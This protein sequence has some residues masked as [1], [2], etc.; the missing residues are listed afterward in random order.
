M[1]NAGAITFM[2]QLLIARPEDE[3]AYFLRR[4][5]RIAAHELAHQWFGDLVTTA[6]WDDIWL[7]EA[8]ATWMTGKVLAALV[9]EWR[10]GDDEAGTTDGAMDED[11]L[12]S[13]RRIRQ[14]IA[15]KDDIFNA[16][17]K[18]TYDKGAAVIGMFERWVGPDR[19]RDGIRRYLA[20]FAFGTATADQFL[21][22]V[23]EAAEATRPLL[24]P[25]HSFLDQPGVPVVAVA[26]QCGDGKGA[27][28]Q[29]GQSR[30]AP[31]GAAAMT[32][33]TWQIPVCARWGDAG[34]E[35]G[36]ACTLLSSATASLSLGDGARCPTWVDA[37]PARG[38][39]R[40][41]YDAR[42]RTRLAA[43]R[44]RAFAPAAR[45]GLLDDAVALAHAG[46]LPFA[47]MLRLAAA[48]A[49]DPSRLVAVAA[50]DAID[51]L[52]ALDLVPPALAPAYARFVRQAFGPRLRALGLAA[53]PHDSDDDKLLRARL[54][55]LLADHGADAALRARAAEQARAWLTNPAALD[56]DLV[57][58]ML[59]AAAAG[60]DPTLYDAFLAEARRTPQRLRR[61]QLLEGLAHFQRPELVRR[62]LPLLITPDF[63]FREAAL[64][65][66]PPRPHL[67]T[68][69]ALRP[70]LYDFVK[71]QFDAIVAR[72]PRDYGAQLARVGAGLCDREHR[73]D[74]ERFFGPR[75]PRYSGGPRLLAQTLERVDIC[76]ALHARAR[77]DVAAF[78][79]RH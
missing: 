48:L 64:L 15:G 38:Y 35:R 45:I 59:S 50:I 76:L 51:D 40:V 75:A 74:L 11:G 70:L 77:A 9:P 62:S 6:W 23:G 79:G 7:N 39:Y 66:W 49:G 18:I 13:A 26:L 33:Q 55:T 69:P 28:L 46:Q 78:L 71:E 29:L 53:R 41:A 22:T 24:A 32:P 42:L 2:Q 67:S 17:D 57:I 37:N 5:V 52:R 8:F 47:D 12:A 34:G 14:I 1:E 72:A 73:A 20:K 19:F 4:L 61:Q 31:L 43:S 68:A 21:A 25:F 10:Y 36:H 54:I 63:D 58:P 44:A 3:S 56:A 30:S 60:D 65:L 16:F 27:H